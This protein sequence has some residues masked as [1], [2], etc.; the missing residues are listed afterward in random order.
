MN[1]KKKL[2]TRLVVGIVYIV[3][4]VALIVTGLLTQSE[5]AFWSSFGLALVV[6]GLVRIRN[7]RLITRNDERMWAQ[8]IAETDERNVYIVHQARSAAFYIYVMIASVAVIVLQ[9]LQMQK[10][11]FLFLIPVL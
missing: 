6:I 9:V 4:G 2:T 10:V 8:E 1:F 11:M 5:N 3:L 7:Y